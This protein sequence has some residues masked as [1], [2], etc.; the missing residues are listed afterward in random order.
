MDKIELLQWLKMEHQEWKAVISHFTSSNWETPGVAGYWSM[1]DVLAHLI[2]WNRRLVDIMQAVINGKPKPQ[3]FWPTNMNSDDQINAWFYETNR[4]HSVSKL[5]DEE[6]QVFKQ[7]LEIVKSFPDNVEIRT[8]REG[9][10]DFYLVQINGQQLNP[11]EFFSHYRDDHKN[12][13]Q[14]FLNKQG[15]NNGK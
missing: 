15:K 10:R 5:L 2:G 14:L 4:N 13:V 7:V 12:Q 9:N 3:P 8:I 6:E 1:K 11:G